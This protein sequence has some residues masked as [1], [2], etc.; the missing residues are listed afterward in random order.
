MEDTGGRSNSPRHLRRQEMPLPA[1]VATALPYVLEALV[2]TGAFVGADYLM[3]GGGG[4]DEGGE[5]PHEREA[6]TASPQR[7][8]R[9]RRPSRLSRRPSHDDLLMQELMN[10]SR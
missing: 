3:G 10:R 1:L 7:R 4:G 5:T 6:I 2:S 9:Y 8:S